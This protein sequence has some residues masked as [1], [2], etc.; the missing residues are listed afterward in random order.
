MRLFCQEVTFMMDCSEVLWTRKC[1]V[2]ALI[3]ICGT[4]VGMGLDNLGVRN[5]LCANPTPVASAT[6]GEAESQTLTYNV[7]WRTALAGVASVR[8]ERDPNESQLKIFGDARS[9][10]FVSTLYRV[11][12]QFES[13]VS[14]KPFCSLKILKQTHE[15][16]HHRE[17]IVDFLPDQKIARL[18]ERNLDTPSAPVRRA[19]AQT[20]E[21]VQDILSALFY[22]QMQPMV[23]GKTVQVAVN[24]GGRTYNVMVDIQQ[25]ETIKTDAGTFQAIRVEPRVS[26]GLLRRPGRLYVWYTDDAEH[27]LVQMKARVSVGTITVSL[28]SASWLQKPISQSAVSR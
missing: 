27:R 17:T 3:L 25:R 5:V 11:E 2:P 21:C 1:L 19:Q 23:L 22:M 8:L 6:A 9:S 15:G 7:Y 4:L 20:P 26:G 18:Q 28:A 16:R 10:R 12:D 24:D 14:L 13:T